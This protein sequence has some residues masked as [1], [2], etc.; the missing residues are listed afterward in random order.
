ML[1]ATSQYALRAL[2]E[3]AKL[4]HGT[5]MLG[6]DLAK[7]ADI[8]ANYLS[9]VLLALRN[10]GLL[11]T[12]R[13]SGGG[14]TLQKRPEEIHLVEVVKV[15]DAAQVDLQ[16][17]LGKKECTDEDPCTAHTAWRDV[18]S[19]FNRFLETTT[20]ADIAASESTGDREDPKPPLT[21]LPGGQ[22]K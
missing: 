17:L 10:V 18:R 6:R 5:A 2:T 9:K 20:I 4:P 13:G 22:Q 7:R 8:P 21:L 11:T 19:A 14:Y 16:C 1:S 15:F 12:A 3:L